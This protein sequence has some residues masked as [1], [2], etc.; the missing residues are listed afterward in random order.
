VNNTIRCLNVRGENSAIN[1]DSATLDS[2]F[3][4]STM[5]VAALFPSM[6]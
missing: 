1:G 6:W 3:D 4:G 5:T 2:I